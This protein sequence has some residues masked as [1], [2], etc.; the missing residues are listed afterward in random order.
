MQVLITCFAVL[1]VIAVGLVVYLTT[2]KKS[3]KND[4]VFV[5]IKKEYKSVK[6]NDAVAGLPPVTPSLLGHIFILLPATSV[7]QARLQPNMEVDA[8]LFECQRQRRLQA[9]MQE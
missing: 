8:A 9:V 1:A 6:S 3:S 5:A 2:R 4:D 7:Q